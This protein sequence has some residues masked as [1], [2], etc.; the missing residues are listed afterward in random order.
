MKDYD[1]VV[2]GGGAAGLLA[3]WAAAKNGAKVAVLEKMEKTAR[4]VRISGKGRCNITNDCRFDEFLSSINT[5]PPFFRWALSSFAQKELL[6]LLKSYGVNTVIERGNR[7]FPESGKAWDVA[8]AILDA[9]ID[10]G[11]DVHIFKEV[12]EI[13][14]KDGRIASVSYR[15]TENGNEGV[16]AVKALILTTGGKSYPRTGST[17][18]GY[19]FLEKLGHHII[20]PI[21][22]LVPLKVKQPEFA[23]IVGLHLKNVEVSL[24]VEGSSVSS[25]FGDLEFLDNGIGGAAVIRQSRK[26]SEALTKKQNVALAIDLKP[27]LERSQLEQ[28]IKRDAKSGESMSVERLLMGL[29]PSKLIKPFAAFHKIGLKKGCNEL[30]DQDFAKIA[31]T[32]KSTRLNVFATAGFDGAIVTA[33]GVSLKNINPKTLESN[34]V[35]GLYVAGELLDLD[36]PTG[37]FNLQIAFSTGYLAGISAA[38]AI[39]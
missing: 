10:A 3:A 7:I 28:R 23:K 36:G 30:T 16:L 18:D 25:E 8:T 15:D 21:P 11:A 27:A 20:Q 29:L 12:V 19:A 38:K 33:G 17:G 5:N 1:L 22:A 34:K 32:L 24:E 39:V 9:A 4:K 14:V 6:D 37:G 13:G 31:R 35:A 2:V 26:A